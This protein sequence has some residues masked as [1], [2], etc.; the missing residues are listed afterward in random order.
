MGTARGEGQ[1]R[2]RPFGHV[3]PGQLA[4]WAFATADWPNRTDPGGTYELLDRFHLEK[5]PSPSG[6]VHHFCWRR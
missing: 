5:I 4:F 1:S 2:E 3:D 6:V